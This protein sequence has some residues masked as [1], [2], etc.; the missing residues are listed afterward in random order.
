MAVATT[1]RRATMLVLSLLAL[2]LRT[3]PDPDPLAPFLPA[4]FPP[5]ALFWE[6]AT[7]LVPGTPAGPLLEEVPELLMGPMP[8][9]P[10]TELLADELAPFPVEAEPLADEHALFPVE[11]EQ[12]VDEHAQFPVEADPLVDALAPFAAWTGLLVD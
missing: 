1:T 7:P 9:P 5:T 8:P 6:D 4:L 11:A 2:L 3:G 12:L 10:E